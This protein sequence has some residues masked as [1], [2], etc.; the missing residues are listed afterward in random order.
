MDACAYAAAG[1][2]VVDP[3]RRARL[4]AAVMLAGSLAWIGYATLPYA[5]SWGPMPFVLAG[6]CLAVVRYHPDLGRR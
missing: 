5:L 6:C 1:T 3:E 2:L 4:A